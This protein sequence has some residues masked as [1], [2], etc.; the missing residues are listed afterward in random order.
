MCCQ[1]PDYVTHVGIYIGVVGGPR[2]AD[3]SR[4]DA[5]PTAGGPA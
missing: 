2:V 5:D 1:E 3:F 4:P